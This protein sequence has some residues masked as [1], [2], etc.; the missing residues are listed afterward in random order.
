MNQKD[1]D[2]KTASLTTLGVAAVIALVFYITQSGMTFDLSTMSPYET[3]FVGFFFFLAVF[4]IFR[5][6]VT[7]YFKLS[8][9]VELLEKIEENTRK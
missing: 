7:W 1:I 6:V 4:L 8:R 2:P 3:I 9:I 5:E